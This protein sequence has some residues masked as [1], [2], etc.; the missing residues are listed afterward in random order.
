MEF[1]LENFGEFIKSERIK[2]GL[3]VKEV[4]AEVKYSKWHLYNIESCE[5]IPS[6]D[7]VKTLLGFYGYELRFSAVEKERS[8]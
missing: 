8:L 6:I 5:R 2:R 1:T 4:A 3:T 7:T